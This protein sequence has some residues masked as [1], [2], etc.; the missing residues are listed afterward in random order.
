[1]STTKN[2]L[3]CPSCHSN[4]N[5][6]IGFSRFIFTKC[7]S[8]GLCFT[9]SI[10]STEEL[11]TYYQGFSFERKSKDKVTGD[12]PS[13]C[14]SLKHFIGCAPDDGIDH[15]FLDYGGGAGIY[16][17]AAEQLGWKA[18]LFDY[19]RDM[20]RYGC[21]ELGVSEGVYDISK[22]KNRQF[23]VIFSF[24]VVEHWNEI[25]ENFKGL[26][27]MLKP[28]GKLVIATPNARSIEKW[29]R[30]QHFLRYYRLWI[31]YLPNRWQRLKLLLKPNSV[32]CWDPPRHLLAWTPDS[33]RFLGE[34]FGLK[35]KVTV[36]YN[37]NQIFEPRAY[38]LKPLRKR[39]R[40]VR[41]MNISAFKKLILFMWEFLSTPCLRLAA[42]VA[43]GFGEQ[44]YVEFQ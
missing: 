12:I 36:G 35:T 18:T 21:E 41:K 19:D 8:C 43:P 37:T 1:M 23:D 22:L 44:L 2:N 5:V 9:A 20:V 26:I 32:F 39:L 38:V 24:H 42:L 6:F 31:P 14:K 17:L 33:F 15:T 7:K 30:P 3:I 25:E 34:R 10:P 29:F 40:N 16:C 27:S 28:G 11:I 13:I 4:K